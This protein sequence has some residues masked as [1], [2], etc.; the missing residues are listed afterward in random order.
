M[1]LVES[2]DGDAELSRQLA[3]SPLAATPPGSSLLRRTLSPDRQPQLE[4]HAAGTVAAAAAGG[5]QVAPAAGRDQQPGAGQQL[6]QQPEAPRASEIVLSAVGVGLQFV[7]LDSP[8]GGNGNG[9][10]SQRPASSMGSNASSR[11]GSAADL[12]RVASLQLGQQALVAAA[13]QAQAPPLAVKRPQP[14][15]A[16]QMLAASLDLNV[17]YKIEASR[18]AHHTMPPFM[19]KGKQADADAMPAGATQPSMLSSSPVVMLPP[20]QDTVQSGR[21]ELQGLRV[22]TRFI[23]GEQ[24]Y[25]C[26]P[27]RAK[28]SKGRSL[29]RARTFWR[30]CNPPPVCAPDCRCG[31]PPGAARPGGRAQQAQ[32]AGAAGGVCPGPLP[33]R[34]RLQPRCRQRPRQGLLPDCCTF[35]PYADQHFQAFHAAAC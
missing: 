31:R 3:G 12:T 32:A 23:S 30:F 13:A 25:D 22:E 1:E 8:A 19:I 5:Q 27:V 4:M 14:A 10:G 16:V 17:A 33:P 11:R 24:Q 20:L 35:H 6:Q 9:A 7:H 34:P 29:P 2:V 15:R 28:Q 21:V 18:A 26:W